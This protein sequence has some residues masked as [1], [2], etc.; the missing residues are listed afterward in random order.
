MP[1]VRAF[2]KNGRVAAFFRQSAGRISEFWGGLGEQLAGAAADADG[3]VCQGLLCDWVWPIAEKRGIPFVPAYT[4]PLLASGD[5]QHPFLLGRLLP[6]RIMR[7]LSHVVVNWGSWRHMRPLIDELRSSLS[8]PPATAPAIN[9][10]KARRI[11]RLQ[12]WSSHVAPRPR[13]WENLDY[14][15]GY[16]RMPLPLRQAVG[17]ATPPPGLTAWLA[18]GSA[19]LYFGFGSMP[20]DDDGADTALALPI[21]AARRLG[22][23]AVCSFARRTPVKRPIP[24]SVF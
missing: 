8:L 3:I 18:S 7:R 19:P 16:W 5:Y 11:P 24:N 22:V 15:T 14:L 23:R 6:S 4:F 17:E 13:E 2:L 1:E 10:I 20:L 9:E 12:M 21:A